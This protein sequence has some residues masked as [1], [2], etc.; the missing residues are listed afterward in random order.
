MLLSEWDVLCLRARRTFLKVC[1]CREL[2]RVGSLYVRRTNP[3]HYTCS[4]KRMEPSAAID[5]VVVQEWKA[6]GHEGL[7]RWEK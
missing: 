4:S 6:R 2:S 3:E 1:V 7:G 5:D